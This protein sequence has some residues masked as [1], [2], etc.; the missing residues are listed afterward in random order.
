M[1]LYSKKYKEVNLEITL[2]H[3]VTVKEVYIRQI[4]SIN[5]IKMDAPLQR[6]FFKREIITSTAARVTRR[7]RRSPIIYTACLV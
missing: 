4:K 1:A 3:K 2:Q 6:F 7:L 5:K